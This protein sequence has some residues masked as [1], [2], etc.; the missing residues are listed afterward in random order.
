MIKAVEWKRLKRV[1]NKVARNRV[2]RVEEEK[3]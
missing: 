2:F 3:K 1:E